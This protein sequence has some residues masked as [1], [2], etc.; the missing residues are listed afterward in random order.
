[1]ERKRWVK[2]DKYW[3]GDAAINHF[4]VRVALKLI[5]YGTREGRK[6]KYEQKPANAE[7]CLLYS[8]CF[9]MMLPLTDGE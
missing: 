9:R 2:T 6:E 1:M 8:Q 5:L 7:A 3:N 4:P